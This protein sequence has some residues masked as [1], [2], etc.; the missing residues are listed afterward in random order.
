MDI[1]RISGANKFDWSQIRFSHFEPWSWP[2]RLGRGS[3]SSRQ[4]P[5]PRRNDTVQMR[6]QQLRRNQSRRGWLAPIVAFAMVV[7]MGAVALVLD[8]LWLDMATGEAQAVAEAAVLASA[9]QL[10]SDD[11]LR[12]PEAA[13]DARIAAA[14]LAAENVASMN[15]VAG[16][17]YRLDSSAGDLTFGVNLE[18][19]ETG[20]IKFVETINNPR[21]ARMVAQRTHARGN[22]VALFLT[23]LTH[24]GGGEVRATAEATIDNHIVGFQS[25]AGARVPMLPLA[26]LANDPSGQ[27]QDTWKVQIEQRR[28]P[29][30]YHFDPSTGE[31]HSGADGIPEITL[32]PVSERDASQAANMAFFDIHGKVGRFPLA[33]QIR[34]GWSAEDLERRDGR[35]VFTSGPQ[36]FPARPVISKTSAAA[37]KAIV[38]ECRGVLLY[39]GGTSTA[40]KNSIRIQSAGLVAGRVMAVR[41]LGGGEYQLVFQPGVLASRSAVRPAD[42][43]IADAGAS[44]NPYI[45][46]LK[47]T[48]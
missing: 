24:V 46:Q 2:V 28:G 36:M 4:R 41:E 8:R 42:L 3:L 23:G 22:P 45:Y 11:D 6:R 31:V 33:E 19:E 16:Q 9:R 12:S 17:P 38:G 13:P 5:A 44:A 32:T 10:A 15:R 47:L 27:R 43:G 7:V 1:P 29:D 21:S 48:Q 14:T 34:L 35:F 25:V 20:E 40:D 26:I 39:Q 18:V 37:L 30:N